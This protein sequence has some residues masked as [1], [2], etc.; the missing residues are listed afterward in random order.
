M[1]LKVTDIR[2]F[3]TRRGVGYVCE[4]NNEN[5]MICNDGNGGATYIVSNGT[6]MYDDLD[7]IKLEEI[8]DDYERQ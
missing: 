7:E 4:T 6:S 3:E 2:Y 1:S 5:V 8:I